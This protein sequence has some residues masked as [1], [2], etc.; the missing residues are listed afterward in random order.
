MTS[1]RCDY[2]IVL[3]QDT[4]LWQACTY[5]DGRANVRRSGQKLWSNLD[6]SKQNYSQT[7][8]CR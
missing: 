3:L 2:K 6:Q 5:S 7:F 8:D 1:Q 4:L